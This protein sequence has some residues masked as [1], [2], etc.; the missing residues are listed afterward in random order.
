MKM[1]LVF[2][3]VQDLKL[4]RKDSFFHNLLF[5]CVRPKEPE[6]GCPEE[7]CGSCKYWWSRLKEAV[8]CWTKMW[9]LTVWTVTCT[10]PEKS[11]ATLKRCLGLGSAKLCLY[12]PSIIWSDMT[13]CSQVSDWLIHF[14]TLHNSLKFNTRPSFGWEHVSVYI[15]TCYTAPFSSDHMWPPNFF[16]WPM[17]KI[18]FRVHNVQSSSIQPTIHTNYIYTKQ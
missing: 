7:D 4:R 5:L 2:A 15:A 14:L 13:N 12:I 18:G 11:V 1:C 8:L 3:R 9:I 6:Q 16:N 10:C 17:W